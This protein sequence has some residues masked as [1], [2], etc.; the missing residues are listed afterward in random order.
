MKYY[1]AFIRWV[2]FH[3]TATIPESIYDFCHA[4]ILD[5]HI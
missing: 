1:V 2:A 5:W 4:K 3:G